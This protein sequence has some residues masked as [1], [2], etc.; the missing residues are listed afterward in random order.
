VKELNLG[1]NALKN[2]IPSDIIQ[3]TSLQ[4]LNLYGNS[5]LGALP[6][7]LNQLPQL[8]YVDLGNNDY[9]GSIPPSFGQIVNLTTLYLDGNTLSGNLQASLVDAP[10]TNLWLNNNNFSG[11]IPHQY[12]NFCTNGTTVRLEGN[13][14]LPFGGNYTLFC[15]N[16]S[17]D[18]ADGDGYCAFAPDC[19]DADPLTFPG[20]AEYCDGLDNDC[21]TLADEGVSIENITWTGSQSKLWSN[22]LNW[23]LS[24]LPQSC[25]NVFIPPAVEDSVIV[26]AGFAAKAYSVLLHNNAFLNI[27]NQGLLT[28]NE[29]GA[30]TNQGNLRIT[31]RLRVTNPL[32]A[33]STAV[34]N[35]NLIT[36]TPNGTIDIQNFQ[37]TG[38]HNYSGAIIANEGIISL[39]GNNTSSGLN[40]ILNFGTINN[41]GTISTQNI[42]GR[43]IFNKINALLN[44]EDSGFL[45]LK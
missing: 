4:R 8:S 1:N 26:S 28:L 6:T 37:I 34:H 22:P 11:C 41:F 3:L 25:H 39:D 27:Q 17:G 38:I 36:V 9:S 2:V 45:D 12:Q 43:D 21:D 16:G 15:Q 31:G 20:A 5:L 24:R 19:N 7:F 33:V 35:Q 10:L 32:S 18:D 13:A 40:G 44:N 42:T 29:G 14:S 30:F 23:N